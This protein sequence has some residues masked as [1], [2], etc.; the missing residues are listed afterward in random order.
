M[1]I[2]STSQPP[3]APQSNSQLPNQSFHVSEPTIPT[4]SHSYS[5]NEEEENEET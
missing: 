5:K 1:R 4:T 2:S 3:I